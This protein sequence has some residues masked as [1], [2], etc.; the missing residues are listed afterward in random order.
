LGANKPKGPNYDIQN[1][2]RLD[3]PEGD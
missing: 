2:R 1:R 3:V